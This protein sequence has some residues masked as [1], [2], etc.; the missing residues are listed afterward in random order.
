MKMPGETQKK[1]KFHMFK[2]L[3]VGHQFLRKDQYPTFQAPEYEKI[4]ATQAKALNRTKEVVNFSPDTEVRWYYRLDTSERQI[5]DLTNTGQHLKSGKRIG[6]FTMRLDYK[7]IV[8]KMVQNPNDIYI[9]GSKTQYSAI[10][11]SIRRLVSHE[12]PVSIKSIK[13]GQNKN[14]DAFAM[15]YIPEW[16]PKNARPLDEIFDQEPE[17]KLE[18]YGY[19]R[20]LV[21][22]LA[23]MKGQWLRVDAKYRDEIKGKDQIK[24]LRQAA[25]T[26]YPNLTLYIEKNDDDDTLS[27][28]LK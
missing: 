3:D 18:E 5:F 6:D 20:G 19:K 11:R 10:Q 25:K 15:V 26:I 9:V 28:C 22:K 23:N 21:R 16:A 1:I 13:V 4:S 24:G 7:S 14:L 2:C 12:H 8:E 27:I 17:A